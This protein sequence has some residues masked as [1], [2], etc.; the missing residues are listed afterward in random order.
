MS[1]VTPLPTLSPTDRVALAAQEFAH[2]RPFVAELIVDA[3]HLS[4]LV[5][6]ANNV[7]YLRWVDRIAE[8]HA[9]ALGHTRAALLTKG[10][11]FFVARHELDY[12][13]ECWE[14]ERLLLA[15]WVRS[16]KRTTSWRETV[17]LRPEPE[18]GESTVIARGRTLWAFVDLATRR[19]ARIPQAIA[20]SFDPLADDEPSSVG[21]P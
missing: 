7:E 19:P 11:C 8:L 4:R 9:D 15:T 21:M 17:I 6:H 16:M 18:A 3:T 5:P 10:H 14:G 2:P 13:A 20:T 12:L 1:D